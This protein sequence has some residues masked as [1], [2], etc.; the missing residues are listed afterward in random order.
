MINTERYHQLSPSSKSTSALVWLLC[1]LMDS[2]AIFEKDFPGRVEGNCQATSTNESR[3]N[4][5]DD[6][7]RLDG[8]GIREVRQRDCSCRTDSSGSRTKRGS[9][10]RLQLRKIPRRDHGL[11][12]PG[13]AAHRGGVH[14]QE[15]PR[16]VGQNGDFHARCEMR[17]AARGARSG[18]RSR[19]MCWG[20]P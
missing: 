14:A 4:P 5:H 1:G 6:R 7:M 19:R 9:A 12:R 2:A 11:H 13:L 15:E 16:S 10:E 20:N 17:V 3:R 18:I 8:I